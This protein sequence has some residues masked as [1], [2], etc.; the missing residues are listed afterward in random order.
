VTP[1]FKDYSRMFK[2]TKMLKAA[3]LFGVLVPGMVGVFAVPAQCDE[4]APARSKA[5]AAV[6]GSYVA[7]RTTDYVQTSSCVFSARCVELNPVFRELV[8]KPKVFAVTQLGMTTAITAGVWKLHARR[9]KLAW[10][11]TG[12]LVGAQAA[13]VTSNARQ[14]RRIQR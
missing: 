4:V 13:V 7:L 6:L 9:P 2:A 10:V 12:A 8:S 5:F 11:L 3:L 1:D 14:L